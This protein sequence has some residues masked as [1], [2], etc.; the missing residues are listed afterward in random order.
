MIKRYEFV[1]RTIHLLREKLENNLP[2]E[3]TLD[4]MIEKSKEL[5]KEI[6]E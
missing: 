5:I 1:E 4:E 2:I 6:F 3:S